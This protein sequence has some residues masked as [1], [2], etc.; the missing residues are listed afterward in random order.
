MISDLKLRFGYGIT[1]QQDG[2]SNYSYLA[3]YT[4]SNATAQ[5]QFG[6]TFY[7]MT[8]PEAYN[9]KLTWEQ[10]ATTNIAVDFGLFDNRMTGSVDFYLKKIFLNV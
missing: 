8:R 1:G 7:G 4:Q 9:P 5:Y 6:N 10:T 2:I 3:R